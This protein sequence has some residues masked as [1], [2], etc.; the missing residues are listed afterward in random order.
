MAV[1]CQQIISILEELAPPRWREEWDNVGLLVGDP[2][3]PVKNVLLT[4]DVTDAVVEEAVDKQIDLI[5]SHHP[6][7]FRPIS[8]LRYNQPL[9]RLLHRLVKE[10]INVYAAHTNLDNA[11]GGV[12]DRLADILG[13]QEVKVLEPAFREKLYKLVVFVPE[14][15]EDRVR[16]AICDEGAGWIGNYSHC[17]FQV[18]GTGT[19]RPLEGT[20]PFIGETG[21]LEKTA[22]FRLETIVPQNRLP[23]VLQAM[24]E[25]H[26]YEEVA[27]DVY[28]LF[29][30]GKEIG[31]GRI[32]LLPHP[33]PLKSLVSLVKEKFNVGSLKVVGDLET[34]IKKVA[35]C[36][37]AGGSFIER[38]FLQGADLYIT[39]D[40]K[41]HEAQH[42]AS[43]GLAVID[44]GHHGTEKV[45]VP[46]LAEFL[47]QRLSTLKAEINLILSEVDTN[48]WQV[49]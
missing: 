47:E 17:T 33:Q 23:R 49:L 2:A 18:A 19:F 48:P 10:N 16:Q 5:I 38:A 27:Y 43:L 30:Q 3:L 25:S 21:R 8:N 35:V 46:A 32:G 28:P 44:A 4:L 11:P 40:L 7:I 13:L 42:A 45:I 6:V 9:G 15:Y 24:N 22:E 36:G 31:L 14:G 1:T 39:G 26:P 20:N 12:N 34:E 29:N 37:G 41:Y